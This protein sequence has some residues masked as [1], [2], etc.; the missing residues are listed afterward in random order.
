MAALGPLSTVAYFNDNGKAE[1]LQFDSF[2]PSEPTIKI[3]HL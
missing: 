2:G 3:V 1:R